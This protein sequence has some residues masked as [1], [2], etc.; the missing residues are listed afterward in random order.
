MAFAPNLAKKMYEN[1]SVPELQ[2]KYEEL[3]TNYC[4]NTKEEQIGYIIKNYL[5]A[6]NDTNNNSK[7]IA[8]EELLKEKT[9]VE[10][11]IEDKKFEIGLIDVINFVTSPKIDPFWTH[12]LI[13]YFEK[14]NVTEDEKIN[15]LIELVQDKV[16][17]N[18][19]TKEVSQQKD[20]N[21]LYDKYKKIA[22]DYVIHHSLKA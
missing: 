4:F 2:K 11:K 16:S 6:S 22:R 13:E 5:N 14:V 21:E 18:D 8:L 7:R 17:F 3:K 20:A 1:L 15:F 19:F 9:G 12:V 10:Y